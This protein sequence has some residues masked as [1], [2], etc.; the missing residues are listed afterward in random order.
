MLTVHGLKNCDT[1]KKAMTW[2]KDNGIAFVFRDV[3][4]DGLNKADVEAWLKAFGP[5]MVINRRGTTWRGLSTEDQ[6][7]EP[8]ALI[9]AF[10]ALVKR[11]VFAWEGGLLIG[12]TDAVR[13]DLLALK[14]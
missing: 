3:R 5:D 12:F 1:C 4:A 6:S 2:L 9:L 11:P 10:P 7:S 14:G 13:K 8:V